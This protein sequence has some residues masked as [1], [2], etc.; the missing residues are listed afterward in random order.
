MGVVMMDVAIPSKPSGPQGSWPGGY[1]VG[2]MIW[3]VACCKGPIN[4]DIYVA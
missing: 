4:D 1:S 3:N 2:D